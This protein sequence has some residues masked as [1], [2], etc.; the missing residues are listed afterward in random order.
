MAV[1]RTFVRV[2]SIELSARYG[3][4]L[5]TKRAP[6]KGTP[7]Q[8]AYVGNLRDRLNLLEAAHVRTKNLGD[9]DG[10]VGVLVVLQDGGHGATSRQAGTVEGVQVARALEV[11]GAVSYTH[12]TLPTIA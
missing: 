12:L 5:R 6:Q 8:I 1:Y 7:L 11:L 4:A 9:R 10:A 2:F 3:K